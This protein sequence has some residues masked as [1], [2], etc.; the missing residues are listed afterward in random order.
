M[1]KLFGIVSLFLSCSV[2]ADIFEKIDCGSFD[3]SKYPNKHYFKESTTS[4]IVN[5]GAEDFFVDIKRS[6][7]ETKSG[8]DVILKLIDRNTGKYQKSF[9][10]KSPHI[11]GKF[12]V[13]HQTVQ[14]GVLVHVGDKVLVGSNNGEFGGEL[15]L[16][17]SNDKLVLLGEMNVEDIHEMP[18]GFVVTSGLAHM[19]SN[20]GEINLI[21]SDFKLNKLFNLIG[22]P[23]S[24]WKL[25]NG[26]LLINNYPAGAQV[27]THSGYL[28]R[29]ECIHNPQQNTDTANSH[30]T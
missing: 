16:I 17:D 8:P 14:P 26:D 2:Q 24:S 6:G 7:Q 21:T 13:E 18:F 19:M 11:K 12:A 15:I 1:I 25:N 4:S 23:A 5:S 29:V 10:R 27:L 30:G 22:Q 3:A 28:K 9:L 20:E